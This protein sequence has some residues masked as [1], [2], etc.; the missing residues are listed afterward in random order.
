MYKLLIV[1]DEEEVR[2]G[3]VKKIDWNRFGFEVI[4]EAEN[5]REA[6][7]IIEENVPDLIITDISMPLMNG[8]ELAAEVKAHYPM[9]KMVILTGFDDFKFAQAA[10]K[11]GVSEYI[12]KPVLPQDLNELLGRL[13]AQM[14]SE[15]EE[16]KD[17]SKL[18]RHYFESLPILRDNFLTSLIIGNPQESEIETKMRFFE[19]N[20][21]GSNFAAAVINLDT[22]AI[23]GGAQNEKSNDLM[24]FAVLNI[25]Q[26]VLGKYRAGAAFFYGDTPVV[27]GAADE[28]AETD[29]CSRLFLLLEEI[30]QNVQKYLGLT[31]TIGLGNIYDNVGRMKESYRSANTALEYKLVLGGNKVIYAGDIEPKK[32]GVIVLGEEREAKLVSSIK[33][34]DEETVADAVALLFVDLESAGA[35]IDEYQLYF[36]EIFTVVL[37]LSR[38]YQLDIMDI[39]PTSY[40]MYKG[41]NN[42]NTM[43]EVKEWIGSVSAELMKKISSNRLSSTQRL[44]EKAKDYIDSNYGDTQL[45]IQKLA[46]HLFISSSYLS[47]IFKKEAQETFL[48]YLI[49]IRLDVAKDLL[50]DPGVKISEVAE[51]VGYP[52]IS[53]FSYF[54]KKNFGVSPREY[55]TKASS[56][57][58]Q[59]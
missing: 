49:R 35:S 50:K 38:T 1:D 4:G 44:L 40:N 37:K 56:R 11:H 24:K 34:G 10:I 36:M 54:F 5:G 15:F 30:R 47:L 23:G 25:A 41:I 57:L 20:I 27:I 42:F 14:D 59:G 13:R 45:S 6:L 28:K 48:K 53:Y 18:E 29:A 33:F 8:I 58:E 3:I 7:D 16:K 22:I 55:K 51:R 31:I 52:D 46:D 26:E 39:L 12:L 43:D 21:A 9:I 2:H 17:R 19:L 32:S